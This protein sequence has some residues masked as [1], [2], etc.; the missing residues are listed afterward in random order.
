MFLSGLPRAGK[1]MHEK[2]F[3]G[4]KTHLNRTKKVLFMHFLLAR[5]N[6]E[7]YRRRRFKRSL[8]QVN[9]SRWYRHKIDLH[10]KDF[11]YLRT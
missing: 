10:E 5:G 4:A 8:S 7:K 9:V 1:I 3:F 11:F 6:P 2:V